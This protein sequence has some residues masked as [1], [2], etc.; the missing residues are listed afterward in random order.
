ML[1]TGA[2]SQLWFNKYT[3]DLQSLPIDPDPCSTVCR[4]VLSPNHSEVCPDVTVMVDWVL[5]TNDV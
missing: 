3:V 2:V 5:E 1:S 4:K